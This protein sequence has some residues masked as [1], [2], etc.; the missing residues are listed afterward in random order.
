MPIP[1]RKDRGTRPGI[2]WESAT[3]RR[4][5][6]RRLWRLL[7]KTQRGRLDARVKPEH[8]KGS[9]GQVAESG[10]NEVCHNPEIATS[11]GGAAARGDEEGTL[12]SS[13]RWHDRLGEGMTKEE[14]TLALILSPGRHRF[15][16]EENKGRTT[17]GT[18]GNPDSPARPENGNRKWGDA[19][20]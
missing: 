16:G 3:I 7:A 8:D 14:G 4:L 19:G 20:F 2:I 9:N 1:L 6:R 15:K 17:S 5:P 11:P 13:V 10:S 18:N 12:D